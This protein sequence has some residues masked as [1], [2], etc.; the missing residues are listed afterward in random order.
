MK[1]PLSQLNRRELLRLGLMGGSAALLGAQR[2]RGQ[3]LVACTALPPQPY[4]IDIETGNSVIEVFPTSPFIIEPFNEPLPIPQAMK[5]GYRQ[6]DGTLTP[7]AP[8]CWTVRS[9]A[10]GSNVQCT[11]GPGEGRQD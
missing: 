11:P 6:P 8:D 10:L 9:S 3:G 5:P 4:D 2:A 1:V 7:S